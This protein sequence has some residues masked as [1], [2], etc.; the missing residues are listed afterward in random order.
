MWL[1]GASHGIRIKSMN[2]CRHAPYPNGN[3]K[4]DL[5]IR[6]EI[7]TNSLTWNA[8][9]NASLK[10]RQRLLRWLD[11][12]TEKKKIGDSPKTCQTLRKKHKYD[13]SPSINFPRSSSHVFEQLR[14]LTLSRH[15][16]AEQ[17]AGQTAKA[18]ISNC[19]IRWTDGSQPTRCQV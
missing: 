15:Q 18:D 6:N 19:Y 2:D 1:N 8:F 3:F 16:E 5:P 11:S 7:R 4:T 10:R 12:S 14:R 17:T 13:H 9:Q